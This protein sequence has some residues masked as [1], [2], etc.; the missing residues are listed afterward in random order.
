MS[1]DFRRVQKIPCLKRVFFLHFFTPQ[2]TW[3]PGQVFLLR[4]V[5][6]GLHGY[7]SELGCKRGNDD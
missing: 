4:G 6:G 3:H 1:H 7:S 2:T 5:P